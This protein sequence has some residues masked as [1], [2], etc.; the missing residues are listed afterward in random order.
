MSLF[1][2]A[3]ENVSLPEF[4]ARELGAKQ[5]M[6]SSGARQNACPNP[7]CTP[8]PGEL[9]V[10]ITGEFFRCWA[11]GSRGDVTAAAS[12]LWG[13]S[14][15]DAARRLLRTRDLQPP[16]PV[17]QE[18][19]GRADAIRR[20][21][22]VLAASPVDPIGVDYLHSRGITDATIREARERQ[23]LAFLPGV[24]DRAMEWLTESVEE[25][26]MRL[27]GMWREGA[28]AP[29]IIFRP[30]VFP[31]TQS[32]EFRLAREPGEREPRALRFG[33]TEKWVWQGTVPGYAIVSGM[34]DVLSLAQLGYKGTIYGLPGATAWTSE[35]FPDPAPGRAQ[36][37]FPG[38]PG[39]QRHSEALRT[40]LAAQGIEAI[41]KLAHSQYGVNGMLKTAA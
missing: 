17:A 31:G 6:T 37:V 16:A 1:K 5:V 3:R 41:I 25:E 13:I 39:G 2:Q 15:A 20:I 24:P 33:R 28:R 30:V 14:A 21:L 4:L 36:I 18:P 29:A 23:M 19:P 35:D 8:R 40:A 9:P 10:S 22:A 26:A 7:E 11:C 27:A 32:A 34:M 12:L 38:S